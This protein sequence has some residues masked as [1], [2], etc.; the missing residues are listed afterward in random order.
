MVLFNERPPFEKAWPATSF[1]VIMAGMGDDTVMSRMRLYFVI[2]ALSS[3]THISSLNTSRSGAR[4][5]T[6]QKL[7]F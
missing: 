3:N 1:R 5:I 6:G 2:P 7:S 4:K